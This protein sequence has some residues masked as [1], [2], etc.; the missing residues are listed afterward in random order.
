MRL[1]S[2][3]YT[4]AS[5]ITTG[6][7]LTITILSFLAFNITSS[8]A[9]DNV[10]DEISITVP[11][12]CSLSSTGTNSHN[13]EI[14][15]GTYNST[16]GETTINAFCNDN[17]GFAIYAVGFTDDEP[18]KNVLTNATLGSTHDIETGTLTTGEDSQWAMKLSTISSPAPTY[19]ITI[20]GSTAD[21]LKE[22]GDP[23]FTS[24]QEVPDMYTK[25]AYRLAGTD[26]GENAEGS[27]LTT[28]YQAYISPTQAAGTYTGQVKYTL[29]HPNDHD[30]PVTHPAILDTGRTV[31]SKLKSVAATVVNGEETIITPTFNIEDDDDWDYDWDYASDN[32]IKSIS[33]HLEAPAPNGFIPSEMNTVSAS[34]SNKPIYIIFDNENDAG[35]MHFY[36]EGEQIFL[37][38]DSSFMF[39]MFFALEDFS[40]LSDW[41]TSNVED[42]SFMLAWAGSSATTFTIDLSSWDTSSV[43]DMSHM[44]Q[45]T[46]GFASSF[47]LDLSSWDTSSVTDMSYMLAETGGSA[48]TFAP[49]L[50]S[51]DTS[52]VTD[53]SYM[54]EGAGDSAD[55]WSIGGIS[56]W[57]T[58]NVT[59]MYYMF[60]STGSSAST[61]TLDLSSWDTSSVTNMGG[62]FYRSLPF[63][64]TFAFSSWDTSSVTN[65]GG[66][67]SNAGY[68]ASAFVLDL[69]SWDT[70]S[71]TDMSGMFGNYAGYS[72]STFTL[73]LS[74]WDTSNVTDM[75][76]T[77]A[78]AGYSASTFALD[79]SSW[80]TSSVTSMWET[81]YLAGH[82]ATTFTL[83]LSS[84]NTSSVTT[85]SSMFTNA[86]PSAT[87]WSVTIPQT[88]GNNISNTTGRIYGQTTSIYGT[89]DSGRS[90][91][92]A[93]P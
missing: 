67:F 58:S 48:S 34:T 65:M 88:N 36:T 23:D 74:S 4:L 43:T 25:V 38:P 16:I 73:N 57:D 6:S 69:S 68:F 92:L 10:V 35:I 44:F 51:W 22:Q 61:F 83:D 80:D 84:W 64:P 52:S 76:A 66:M 46:G 77:F 89:P 93:Q 37:S 7:L 54:F 3:K 75:T 18:G 87:T 78:A 56:S 47:I 9:A 55:D 90:F 40:D 26:T 17:E 41:D 70:S 91:T 39:Y 11:V 8:F 5:T 13:A 81:F 63:G 2:N 12:S 32:Y 42:M 33:I 79:L 50:S 21:A 59:N 62:M 72:A 14:Y 60:A 45:R 27:V 20:A 1:S 53:M 19:P 85:T 28:T 24:F 31:N 82:S 30:V 49:N 71:V 15:N 86:G 29:V